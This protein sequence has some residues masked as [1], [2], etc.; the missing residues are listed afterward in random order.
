MIAQSRRH[1]RL[2]A[3]MRAALVFAWVSAGGLWAAEPA[4]PTKPQPPAPAPQTDTTPAAPTGGPAPAILGQLTGSN[5]QFSTDGG[6]TWRPAQQGTPLAEGA[7][8]RTGFGATCQVSFADQT[9]LQVQPLSC[10]RISRYQAGPTSQTIQAVLP[11][12]AVRCGVQKGRI[13]SDTQIRT[14][15]STL[16]IRGTIAYVAYDPGLRRCLLAVDES[17]PAIAALAGG[18]CCGGA[19]FGASNPNPTPA[20]AYELEAGM[21][22][23]CVLG[24]HLSLAMFDRTVWV[25]GNLAVGDVT[26]DEAGPMVH[27]QADPANPTGG[28][29]NYR[30]DKGRAAERPLDETVRFPGGDVPIGG[31]GRS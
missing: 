20:T 31:G 24:R 23:N 6:K 13:E 7:I 3:G 8:V 4:A 18:G 16:S 9:I 19:S 5:A 30:N 10:V 27:G 2:A 29:E 26:P 1:W 22:T 17:G 15:V 28:A 14:P 21:Y 25:T 12:G 11:Y